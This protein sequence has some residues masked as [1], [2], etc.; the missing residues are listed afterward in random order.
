MNFKI[1]SSKIFLIAV[2]AFFASTLYTSAINVSA[3]ADGYYYQG[4]YK[5]NVS[6]YLTLRKYDN[7]NSADIG[8]IPANA[9]FCVSEVSNNYMGKVE[10]QFKIN[11]KYVTKTGY[12]NLHYALENYSA[13]GTKPIERV[14]NRYDDVTI[15]STDN[16]YSSANGYLPK[17]A[18]R[19]RGDYSKSER[20]MT[21]I[22]WVNGAGKTIS[23]W[24]NLDYMEFC[25]NYGWC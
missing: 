6:E 20:R 12:V 16:V 5:A 8:H 7:V 17:G 14:P 25:R 18:T 11:G 19:Q 22:S 2:S 23:G 1:L 3:R 9:S 4:N 21:K 15:R 10:Y 13:D 24:I